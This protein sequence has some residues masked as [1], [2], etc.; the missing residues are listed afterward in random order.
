MHVVAGR[1]PEIVGI[2]D[3]DLVD[4]SDHIRS[5]ASIRREDEGADREMG[6]ERASH[7][8][9]PFSDENPVSGLGTSAE[10]DISEPD[11][12]GERVGRHEQSR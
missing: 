5:T 8:V 7:N 1:Q 4:E 9:D 12:I 6:R 3:V 2:A 10:G 11:E